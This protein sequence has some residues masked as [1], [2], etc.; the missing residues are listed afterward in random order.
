[1]LR[2]YGGVM[3]LRFLTLPTAWMMVYYPE[4]GNPK[5]KLGKDKDCGLSWCVEW[6]CPEG[7]V[8]EAE[9]WIN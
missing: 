1:M 5:E 3:S 6:R 2:G 9:G 4:L 8:K 7:T